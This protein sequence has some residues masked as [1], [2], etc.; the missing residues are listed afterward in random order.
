M[1]TTTVREVLLLAGKLHTAAYVIRPG[2]YIVRRLPQLS[3]LNGQEKV[4]G[5]ERKGKG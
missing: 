2:G 4:E 1:R 5:G 3:N